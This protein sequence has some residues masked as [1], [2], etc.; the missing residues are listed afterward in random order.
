VTLYS[1]PID[2][3][4]NFG[5][6]GDLKHFLIKVLNTLGNSKHYSFY[7]FKIQTQTKKAV[8]NG[9]YVLSPMPKGNACTLLVPILFA[10]NT[11]EQRTYFAQTKKDIGAR[12]PI[13]ARGN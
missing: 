7:F 6:R 1:A 11:Q 10:C 9:H 8:N 3:S 13:N 4:E 2:T 12:T 5:R